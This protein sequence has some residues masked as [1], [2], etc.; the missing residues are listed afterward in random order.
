MIIGIGVAWGHQYDK[1]RAAGASGARFGAASRDVQELFFRSTFL[2]MGHLAKADGRVSEDEIRATRN[3]MNQ[4]RLGPEQ[5]KEAIALFSEGKSPE[6][7]LDSQIAKLRAAIGGQKLLVRSFLE[8]QF[9]LLLSKGS[10]HSA[11]RDSLWRIASGLGFSRIELAQLEAILRA[12]QSFGGQS[13]A[14]SPQRDLD[15][16]YKALGVESGV[17]DK[18]VKTAY[19]RLMNQHH[20]DKLMAK[21]LPDSMLEVSKEKTREIRAAYEVIKAARGFK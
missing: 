14:Q 10:I 15:Q 17:S 8:I 9:Y 4:L 11:E 3:V 16:A 19:R 18:D 5:V 2:A 7:D 6:F 13:A 21:G 12:Q 20:P 1:A